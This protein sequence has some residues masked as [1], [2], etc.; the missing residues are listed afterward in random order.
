[1]LRS[2]KQ[3]VKF[4]IQ[5]YS[6]SIVPEPSEHQKK[7]NEYKSELKKLRKVYSEEW[8]EKK[9]KEDQAS[10]EKFKAF[11]DE[12]LT[13]RKQKAEVS[14]HNIQKNQEFIE[15][16][17]RERDRKRREKNQ[18]RINQ[19]MIKSSERVYNLQKLVKESQ[20]YVT[21]ENIDQHLMKQLNPNRIL[22]PTI[23]KDRVG[24][25]DEVNYYDYFTQALEKNIEPPRLTPLYLSPKPLNLSFDLIF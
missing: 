6:K 16:L 3:I 21:K 13:Y 12:T 14:R 15:F 23:F 2:S 8:K 5:N 19:E 7:E 20:Y 4:K 10:V 1:M 17:L 22:T 18:N 9:M 25:I 24:I 11:R